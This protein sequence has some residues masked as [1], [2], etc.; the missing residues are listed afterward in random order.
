LH[1]S[2]K[3]VSG[4]SYTRPEP[5]ARCH[6]G[7]R[8]K[9]FA[10]IEKWITDDGDRPILWLNG[11]AGS[12][13]SAISQ[14]VA[15]RYAPRIAASFFFLR[16]AGL[17]SQI[18]QLIPTLAYQASVYSPASRKS[19]IKA[20]KKDPDLCHGQSFQHQ[21][22]KLLIT[23][24]RVT[25]SRWI[26]RPK[27]L[28]VID[29]LDECNDKQSMSTFIEAIT[30]ICSNP[31]FR[32]PFRL[33]L[34]SRV[35]EHIQEQFNNPI[36]Q[37]IINHLS[38]QKFDATNDIKLYLETQLSAV[39]TIK[40]HLMVDVLHPWP[41][42]SDL[43]QLSKNVAGS[44]IIASTLVEFIKTEKDTPQRKLEI[45]LNMTNGLDPVYKQVITDTLKEN[46][47]L[48]QKE[49]QILELVLA[50]IVILAE[51]L[52]IAAL[53]KLL[54]VKASSIAYVLLGL[55]AILLIPE[56]DHDEPVKLFHT[57]LRDYLCAKER[58]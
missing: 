28:V 9:V 26:K 16:G 5:V 7:T 35:E 58:S 57:S 38:L 44:F 39:Y 45:A 19:I 18:Q 23:P 10:E 20:L 11:P 21:L 47:A 49:L 46:K 3:P 2:L 34:T 6:P 13:K 40:K 8:L 15:E 31:G 24:I 33:I 17:R 48:Q 55:Q 56:N 50:V 12:G 32:L 4:A 51:P 36:T 29:A 37:S 22:Q 53:G 1:K 14:T 41:S 27:P 54:N 43:Q 42:F 25:R 52:S 30:T